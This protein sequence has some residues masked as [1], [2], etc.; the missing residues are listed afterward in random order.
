MR[1]TLKQIAEKAGVH[2]ST[3]DKVL[4][5]RPGVSDAVRANVQQII[6]ELG[7]QPSKAGRTLQRMGKQYHI[8]VLLLN[9]DAKPY[10]MEGIRKA[11]DESVFDIRIEAHSSD[12]QDVEHQEQMLR[13]TAESSCDGII[14]YPNYDRRIRTAIDEIVEKGIPV[15]T[16]NSDIRESSRLCYVGQNGARGAYIAGRMMG[17]LTGG[18]GKTAVITSAISSENCDYHVATRKREFAAFIKKNYPDI[19]IVRD[20]ESFENRQYTYDQT[21]KLLEEVPDLKGIYITCGCV[22]V[23]G[24]AVQEAGRAADVHIVSFED[25]PEIL[26]LMDQNVIDCTI[27]SD[28]T[29]QGLRSMQIMMEYLVDGKKPDQKMMYIDSQILVRESIV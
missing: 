27:G 4:H 3:V 9:V 1:V 24:K 8:V 28:L 15:I 18:S 26:E 29:D 7:Y 16:V 2:I 23:V 21:R 17:L 25:Y 20:I 5:N 11:A 19:R 14:L 12:F 13:Q 6:D 10:I 22:D